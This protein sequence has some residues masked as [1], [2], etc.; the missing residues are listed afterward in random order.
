M[1]QTCS[2]NGTISGVVHLTGRTFGIV[3][4][5][6]GRWDV[7]QVKMWPLTVAEISTLQPNRG[8]KGGVRIP[9]FR[10]SGCAIDQ[11]GHTPSI[12]C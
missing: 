3:L 4:H 9:G 12:Q 1:Y 6:N 2:S 10:D 8:V 11:H 7:D 5:S